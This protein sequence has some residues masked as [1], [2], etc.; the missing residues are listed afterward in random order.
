MD[1]RVFAEKVV[2]RLKRIRA[3]LTRDLR[4]NFESDRLNRRRELVDDLLLVWRGY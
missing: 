3:D 1:D 4:D 2:R